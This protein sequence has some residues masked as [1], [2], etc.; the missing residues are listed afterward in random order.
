MEYVIKGSL[1]GISGR[2]ETRNYEDIRE[3]EFM[4]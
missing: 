1:I 2:L 4:L 3:D